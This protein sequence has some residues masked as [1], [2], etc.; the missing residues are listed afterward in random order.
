MTEKRSDED[1]RHWL[2]NRRLAYHRVFNPENRDVQ[3]LM[4][5]LARFC[6]AHEST[7]DP[8]PRVHA[9]LEGRKEVWLRIQQHLQMSDEDLWHHFTRK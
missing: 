3:V 8:D 2:K 1:A 9:L 7:F 4:A 5:D 6:R